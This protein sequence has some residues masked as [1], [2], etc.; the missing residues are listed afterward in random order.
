MTLPRT[1]AFSQT[2][3]KAGIH[4]L[5]SAGLL[6]QAELTR[7]AQS[8]AA[9]LSAGQVYAE[10]QRAH[11]DALILEK[12]I[13]TRASPLLPQAVRLGLRQPEASLRDYEGWFG[14]RAA[15][16]ANPGDVASMF[17]PAAYLT[18]LYREARTFYP[19]DSGWH[20]DQRRPDIAALALSQDNMDAEISALDLSIEIMMAKVRA[21]LPASDTSDD[22][23]LKALSTD[24]AQY[25]YSLSPLP[26]RAATGLRGERSG[27]YSPCRLPGGHRTSE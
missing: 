26:C 12:G 13:L 20:I 21:G 24:S 27:L 4:S 22:T 19:E 1:L 17:S 9:S 18:A 3:A 8:E 7:L 14:D 15:Q 23:V 5:A 10:A 11:K 6:N 2:A 16:Y 25:W